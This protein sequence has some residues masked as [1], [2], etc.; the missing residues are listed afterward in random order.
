MDSSGQKPPG[1]ADVLCRLSVELEVGSCPE[2]MRGSRRCLT[3]YGST[4]FK[5]SATRLVVDIELSRELGSA[6][7]QFLQLPLPD[8][9]QDELHES[10][11]PAS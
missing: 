9:H 4:P 1:L 2:E 5:I 8:A 11:E 10:S 3:R 7:A 6:H